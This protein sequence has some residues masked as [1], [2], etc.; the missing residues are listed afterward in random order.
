MRA[1]E[2]IENDKKVF[3]A[4]KNLDDVEEDGSGAEDQ[5]EYEAEVEEY[6]RFVVVKCSYCAKPARVTVTDLMEGIAEVEAR[7]ASE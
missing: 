1:K 7:K 2:L 3:L 5:H 6:E 4:D